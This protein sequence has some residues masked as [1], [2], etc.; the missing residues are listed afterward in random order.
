MSC[1]CIGVVQ[2]H[3]E[4]RHQV[5]CTEDIHTAL[6]IGLA[7]NRVISRP[8]YLQ[9]APLRM[10][11]VYAYAARLQQRLKDMYNIANM[12]STQMS[13]SMIVSVASHPVCAATTALSKLCDSAR[14][15][16]GSS[17]PKGVCNA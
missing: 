12:S 17:W 2:V 1:I 9:A 16:E 4:Y 6:K 10:V 5:S 15:C 13:Y 7:E 8:S 14:L 3:A 11:I